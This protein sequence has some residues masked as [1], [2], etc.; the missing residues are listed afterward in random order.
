M[1]NLREKHFGAYEVWRKIRPEACPAWQDFKG[2]LR[3]MGDKPPKYHLERFQPTELYDP[4]NCRWVKDFVS[5]RN[6]HP[7]H[8]VY[9]HGQEKPFAQWC[10][11]L[12]LHY[13][14][15]KQ[16]LSRGWPLERVFTC[17]LVD[18]PQESRSGSF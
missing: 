13:E 16:R 6:N 3:D 11:E 2:F 15:T 5:Q 12:D 17:R 1:A 18:A 8:L 9:W 14:R 7:A 10:E 4:R